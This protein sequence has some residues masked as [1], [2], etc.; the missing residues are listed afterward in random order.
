MKKRGGRPRWSRM[1]GAGESGPWAVGLGEAL[2]G[3]HRPFRRDC[4]SGAEWTVPMSGRRMRCVRRLAVSC[5]RAVALTP[6]Q[7]PPSSASED[8]ELDDLE[9]DADADEADEQ[10]AEGEAD[11]AEDVDVDVD[12]ELEDDE[13]EPESVSSGSRQQGRS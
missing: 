3:L 10:D 11:D 5:V 8:M 6:P 4:P 9:D 7:C 12:G 1:F 2:R 13:E